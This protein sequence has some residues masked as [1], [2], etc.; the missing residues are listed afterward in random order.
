MRGF[1]KRGIHE[2][3]ASIFLSTIILEQRALLRAFEIRRGFQIFGDKKANKSVILEIEK[4][5]KKNLYINVLHTLWAF[6]ICIYILKYI[7]KSCH[8]HSYGFQN[9][10]LSSGWG[11]KFSKSQK[12]GDF[13]IFSM[14]AQTYRE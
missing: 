9:L 10:I 8:Q 14:K 12:V 5:R 11:S 7:L 3:R 1:F 2:K 13:S 6:R 4:A